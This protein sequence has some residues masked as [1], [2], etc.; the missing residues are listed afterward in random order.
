[1]GILILKF[2]FIHQIHICQPAVLCNALLTNP[3]ISF[4][5][6]GSDSEYRAIERPLFLPVPVSVRQNK[7][8]QQPEAPYSIEPSVFHD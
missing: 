7:V 2:L 3:Q 4:D 5:E 6:E 1:M 8:G